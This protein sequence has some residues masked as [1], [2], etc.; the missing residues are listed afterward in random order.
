ME[1]SPQVQIKHFL[2]DSVE[3]SVF[4]CFLAFFFFF[5]RSLQY[6]RFLTVMGIF[7]GHGNSPGVWEYSWVT[8]KSWN[9][10]IVLGYGYSP[11]TQA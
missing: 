8:G 3:H 7:L 10:G 5:G 4:V 6:Q 1:N 2:C 11:G 9:T